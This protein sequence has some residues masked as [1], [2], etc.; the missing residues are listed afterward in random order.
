MICAD[1]VSAI[2]DGRSPLVLTER[3]EHLRDLAQR[4][5]PDIPHLILL[6]GGLGRKALA[7]TLARLAEIPNDEGCAILA[8]GKYVGEGFDHAL[9]TT[10]ERRV[11][12]ILVTNVE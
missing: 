1:V 11:G 9:E 12:A 10:L 6:Q 5:S 3:T 4:L 8:T 7:A 2:R